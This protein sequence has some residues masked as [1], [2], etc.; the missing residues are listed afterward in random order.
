VPTGAV[1][2]GGGNYSR[3]AAPLSGLNTASANLNGAGQLAAA[4][5]ASGLHAAAAL[6]GSGTLAASASTGTVTDGR[7]IN[8]TNTGIAG[9]GISVGSLTT[10][11]G[12]QS[13]TTAQ[14]VSLKRFTGTVA[15]DAAVA[16]VFDRCQFEGTGINTYPLNLNAGVGC[17]VSYCT[18]ITASGTSGLSSIK[19][20]LGGGAGHTIN[21]CDVSGCEN[22]M[23]LNPSTTVTECY[24]HDAK[25]DADPSGH[26]DVIELF[27]AVGGATYT[28]QRNHLV[29]GATNEDGD[30]NASPFSTNCVITLMT[31]T[32]NYVEDGNAHLLIDNQATGGDVTNTDFSRNYCSGH[33]RPSTASPPGP[34]RF[35]LLQNND[36]RTVY[37]S[38]SA[39]TS[40]GSGILI[41]SSGS[42]ANYWYNC[43]DLDA[44]L[45]PSG[46]GAYSP[47]R[48]GT[49]AAAGQ[50][51]NG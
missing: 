51:V 46:S 16:V 8:A 47:N 30:I 23:S 29:L 19:T 26:P 43:A 5:V 33:T 14:T 48:N 44:A 13:Y 50:S 12:N 10:I 25:I 35:Q 1:G 31:I 40:A 21:R 20:P 28:I 17:T 9:A 24:L 41:P 15:V 32:D 38:R 37:G 42:D 49:I 11:S 45:G 7:A 18:F 22:I 4:A 34:G 27:G 36:G 39:W 3:A 2:G 6:L